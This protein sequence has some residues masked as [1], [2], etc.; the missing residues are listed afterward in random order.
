MQKPVAVVLL[1]LLIGAAG[2]FFF[3]RGE[4]AVPIAPGPGGE[5]PVVEEQT[6]AQDAVDARESAA[7]VPGTTQRTEVAVALP[8]L[9][10]DP[11]IRAGLSGFRGR[12][13]THDKVPVSDCGVRFY[14]GAMDVVLSEGADV[15]ADGP[16][17]E[18]NYIAGET[19]TG[20]D[21]T[22]LVSGVWPRAI[23]IMFAGIGTDA[24]MH[25]II[26]RTPSPGQI[27]DLGD[28]EL[29]NAGVI[30]GKVFDD[31]GEPLAGALV[32]AAD[33][34][35]T[36]AGFFPLE[37]FDPKGGLLIRENDSPVQVVE[38]PPW[39]ERAFEH[40][41]IPTTHT[42]GDGAFR[43]VGVTP[44]S[45]LL[46]VTAENHL[47]DVKPSVLVRAGE[48]KDVGRIRLRAGEELVGKVVDTA[49]KAVEGAE[50][51]AGSTITVAPVDLARRLPS[52]NAEGE[53]GGLGFAPGKVT[54]AARRGP[55]HAWV[56]AEPQSI[57]GDV[58]VTLP[59]TWG[60]T[61]TVLAE[62]GEAVPQ[63]RFRLLQGKPGDGVAELAV[64]GFVPP[65]DLRDRLMRTEEGPWRID[66]LR[67]GKYT[68]VA[69]A[70]GHATGF[71]AFGIEDG[72]ATITLQLK[73]KREF[74]VRVL[75]HED[76][77]IKNAAV[78]ADVRGKSLYEMPIHC[79]R[80]KAD[81]TLTI[82]RFQADKLRVS[83][84]HPKWGYVHGEATLGEELVLRLAPPGSLEGT[85]T[86]N[87]A[88]PEPGKYTVIVEWRRNDGPR[89]PLEQVPQMVTA[90]EDG[91]FRVEALQPGQ[92]RLT[93]IDSLE[94]MRSPG[95]LMTMMMSARMMSHDQQRATVDVVS[96]QTA[97][98]FLDTGKKPIEGPTAHLFGSVMID[99]RLAEG[100]QVM[101]WIENR[102]F[103]GEVDRAGRFDLGI[104]PAGNAWVS[105]SSDGGFF[106]MS[107]NIWSGNL[108]LAENEERELRVEVL[109]SSMSGTVVNPDGSPVTGGHVM[110]NGRL[111]DGESNVYL[112]SPIDANG[113]FSF[114]KVP[115]GVWTIE[116]R[117]RGDSS[118]RGKLEGLELTAGVPAT[119]LRLEVHPAITV[120]GKV[121][122]TVFGNEE[123]RWVW[124]S[125]HS[126]NT[127]G[128]IG[129]QVDGIGVD[130][131]DGSFSTDD[132]SAGSY[133]LRLHAGWQDRSD[134]YRCQNLEVPLQ[135][136]EGI[137]VRG[138]KE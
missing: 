65:V 88:P 94:S 31:D 26:T 62:D 100:A 76:Q 119:M 133:A 95:G 4:D 75:D 47:A 1:L 60:A 116:V 97:T 41:P 19:Q 85:L 90:A 64:F 14:R 25:Q 2:W 132:L 117:G 12:V 107:S 48:E 138:T 72:D 11:E 108:K 39:V 137:L 7:P 51:M 28:V 111:K 34:P 121:D 131:D 127:D 5:E 54:V 46:A 56:V 69:D 81:G 16:S 77:P 55:G 122:M 24:P 136:I 82:D 53:F 96:G 79:G 86:E 92:Y 42:D 70:P 80:T 49:G 8:E 73:R 35:G 99:G 36:L 52:T 125:V 130:K 118:M 93:T 74:A 33:I 30:A 105:V 3:L 84:D 67:N 10:D 29:P 27:I 61:V 98:V 43:L 110:A 50:V 63:P 40:V 20:E 126:L 128:T 37:R 102:R 32:R 66:N 114:E 115:E 17:I 58:V 44:G 134:T 123:P 6:V 104:V 101:A 59:A 15:F 78:Y 103:G 87:G 106:G 89:G 13:V 120:K 23:Y 135:G 9:L 38:M 22:F 71:H 45:N 91:S 113:N 109:T 112:H 124:L 21:G 83:A 57:L 18:P 129:D 68:L